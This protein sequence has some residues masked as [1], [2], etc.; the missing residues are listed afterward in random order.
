MS[1]SLPPQVKCAPPH[2]TSVLLLSSFSLAYFY[3]GFNFTRQGGMR[4]DFPHTYFTIL[5]K[6]PFSVLM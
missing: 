4:M 1:C 6:F 3:S 5:L 2:P